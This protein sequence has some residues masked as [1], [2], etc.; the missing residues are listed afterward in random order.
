MLNI[1]YNIYFYKQLVASYKYIGNVPTEKHFMVF[2]ILY[3]N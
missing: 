1:E 2:I 3:V